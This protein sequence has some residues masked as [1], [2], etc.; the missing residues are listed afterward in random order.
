[1]LLLNKLVRSA[2][3]VRKTGGQSIDDLASSIHAHGLI[4]NLTVTEQHKKANQPEGGKSSQEC[5]G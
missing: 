4:H 2:L 3:N 1:M 5:D